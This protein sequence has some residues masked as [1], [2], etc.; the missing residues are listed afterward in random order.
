MGAHQWERPTKAQM[1]A[2]MKARREQRLVRRELAELGI[3][4]VD[5]RQMLDAVRAIEA[6]LT[7]PSA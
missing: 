7:T 5:T 4:V 3:F 6:G 2:R 1:L